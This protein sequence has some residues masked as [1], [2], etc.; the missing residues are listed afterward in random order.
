MLQ[1]GCTSVKVVSGRVH[2]WPRD[3]AGHILRHRGRGPAHVLP[4]HRGQAPKRRICMTLMVETGRNSEVVE[5]A[6]ICVQ[7]PGSHGVHK[8]WHR[9][10]INDVQIKDMLSWVLPLCTTTMLRV[11]ARSAHTVHGRT[12]GIFHAR[13]AQ[14]GTPIKCFTLT[15]CACKSSAT[16]STATQ[17]KRRRILVRNGEALKVIQPRWLKRFLPMARL[18]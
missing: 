6:T 4:L 8:A 14:H 17:R 9:N 16:R 12:T 1:T 11:V 18:Q 5:A 15:K 2:R 10:I 7:R 13:F 3:V